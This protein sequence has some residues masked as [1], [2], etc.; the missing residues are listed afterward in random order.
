[1]EDRRSTSTL[2]EGVSIRSDEYTAASND[3]LGGKPCLGNDNI[4]SPDTS[5]LSVRCK[6]PRQDDHPSPASRPYSSWVE[7]FEVHV[8]IK[9]YLSERL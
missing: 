6:P 3:P 2:V 9:L 4:A 5:A 7:K 8:Y 1:M